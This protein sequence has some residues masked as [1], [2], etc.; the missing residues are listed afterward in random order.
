[1]HRSFRDFRRFM[2]DNGLSPSQVS[3]LMRLH[4][5]GGCGVSEIA[6]H[7]GITNAAASQMVERLFQAGLVHRVETPGDRRAK[8]LSLTPAGRELVERSIDARKC[9]MESLTQEL[10]L[11]EQENIAQALVALTEAARRLE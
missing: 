10:S 5:E 4:Y 8:S 2:E 3:A 6:A 7:L 9:W 11:Q 1:M